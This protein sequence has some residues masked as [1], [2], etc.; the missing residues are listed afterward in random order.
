MIIPEKKFFL[1]GMGDR[2][3]YIYRDGKLLSF[4]NYRVYA[5]FKV[6]CEEIIP[7]EYTV[8]LKDANGNVVIYENEEGVYLQN[9][10]DRT[11]CLTSSYINLPDFG[12]SAYSNT[13]RILH[14]EILINIYNGL[15]L[16]NMFV[17]NKPWYRDSATMAMV[18]KHTGNLH[19]ISDW[20]A[21]VTEMYDRNN[22]GMNE[23]DNLGQLMYILAL[24]GNNSSSIVLE[25]VAEAKRRAPY[26]VLDGITD[27]ANHAVYQTKWLKYGLYTLGLDSEWVKIPEIRDSYSALFWMDYI[28]EG[29]IFDDSDYP[30]IENYPYL[31]WAKQHY[32]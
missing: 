22:A 7:S 16:P 30:Y 31:W 23:P 21:S 26:G 29:M 10:D 28:D 6:L 27:G 2:D 12:D 4:P 14:H 19:L 13:L 15:P 8:R 18:L 17:Y 11:E 25:L 24:T 9:N 5:D 32:Y 1:F 20:A 3:K